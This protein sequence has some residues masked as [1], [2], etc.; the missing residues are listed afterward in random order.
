MKIVNKLI[1]IAKRISVMSSR[2]L[3]HRF[4]EQLYLFYLQ[5]VDLLHFTPCKQFSDTQGFSFFAKADPVPLLKWQLDKEYVKQLLSGKIP[6]YDSELQWSNSDNFWNYA[7]DTGKIWPTK[8]FASIPYRQNNPYGDCRIAWEASRLQH[9]LALAVFAKDNKDEISAKAIE[10]IEA[11][12]FSWIKH[13]PPYKGIHYIASMECALRLICCCHIFGYLSE[14]FKENQKI[15]LALVN[16]ISS[17]ANLIENRLS[18]FS[19]TGNHTIA[20]AIGLLYAGLLFPEF[21]A[22]NKWQQIGLSLLEE[23]ADA[24]IFQDG[25]SKEQAFHYLLLVLD[26][27]ALAAELLKHKKLTIP[28]SI[29]SAVDRGREFLDKFNLTGNNIPSI[30]DSDNGYA[31]SK[32]MSINWSEKLPESDIATLNESGYTIYNDIKN[33]FRLILDHGPLGMAPS[34]GHGH[35]D[36]LSVLL[37]VSQQ[38]ILIDPGTGSYL[39]DL[40]MRRYFRSTA[41][42]NTV[43]VDGLDQA[44][45]K[46][47]F[48]WSSPYQAE[49]VHSS[50]DN[51]C[52]IRLLAKHNGYNHIGVTH[53]RGI[54]ILNNQ[55][56][57]MDFLQGNSTHHLQINWNLGTEPKTISDGTVVFD[58]HETEVKMEFSGGELILNKG[59][60]TPFNAWLSNVYGEHSPCP[61]ISISKS[62]ELPHCF[63]TL[64][65][66]DNSASHL[67]VECEMATLK[68]LIANNHREY[69]DL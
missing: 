42:H 57:I 17:H 9:L 21:T 14:H 49:L 24:Q 6:V 15:Q 18:L 62:C 22:A 13:N 39:G 3:I 64:I 19:S 30:G 52:V 4:E 63:T 33:N 11:Q 31:L 55:V 56:L 59:V 69:F 53:Y 48:M 35:A 67:S 43:V 51:N 29:S 8:F 60:K 36:A 10:Q 25:G 50:T 54:T 7:P 40:E 37:D 41:A 68:E 47:P 61:K 23:Q 28:N 58:A 12:F 16:L 27:Y 44:Q 38:N 66:V 20:E 34:F 65:S 5:A 46:T 32:F 45:Q 1:W 2:E 26:I